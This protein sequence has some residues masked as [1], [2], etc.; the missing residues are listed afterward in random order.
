MTARLDRE[1]LDG[2]AEGLDADGA[3]RL[4]LADGSL[5]RVTAVGGE[6]VADGRQ[7]PR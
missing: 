1:T 6:D 7:G 3:L 4:R 2:V 5:R